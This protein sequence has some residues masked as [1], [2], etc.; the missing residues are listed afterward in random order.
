MPMTMKAWFSSYQAAYAVEW[1]LLSDIPSLSFIGLPYAAFQRKFILFHHIT[2]VWSMS[3]HLCYW[4]QVLEDSESME[5]G[6][7]SALTEQ[8]EHVRS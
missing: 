3:A 6:I 4:T 7:G 8:Q 5:S 2:C 1:V